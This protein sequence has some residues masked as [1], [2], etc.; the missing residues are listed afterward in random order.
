MNPVPAARTCRP[1]RHQDGVAAV[2]LALLM[3]ILMAFLALSVFGISVFWHYTITQ[4][5]VQNA[6]HY[7]S[8]VS[9]SEMMTPASAEAAG[10]LAQEIVRRQIAEMSPATEVAKIEAFCDDSTCGGLAAGRLPS[11]VRVKFSIAMFDP[12]GM[13]DVGWYGLQ[14]SANYSMRY[15]GH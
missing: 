1:T 15:V 8:T 5:A 3:P 13:V 7:L 11:T 6:A 4:K 9:A 12:T 14:I 2:E 10:T